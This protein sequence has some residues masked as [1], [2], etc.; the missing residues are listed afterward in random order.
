MVHPARDVELRRLLVLLG[1][2]QIEVHLVALVVVDGPDAEVAVRRAY[3]DQVEILGVDEGLERR[4]IHRRA[5]RVVRVGQPGRYAAAVDDLGGAGAKG[6]RDHRP[7]INVEP[8]AGV[9]RAVLLARV[10]AVANVRRMRVTSV[11]LYPAAADIQVFELGASRAAAYSCARAGLYARAVRVIAAAC[12]HYVAALDRNALGVVGLGDGVVRRVVEQVAARAD[13]RAAE[14]ALGVDPAAG[15]RGVGAVGGHVFLRQEVDHDVVAAAVTL[16]VGG[17][18]A[19]DAGALLAARGRYVGLA[20]EQDV[21]GVATGRVSA[22]HATAYSCATFSALGVHGAVR[23]LD[24]VVDVLL[25]GGGGVHGRTAASADAGRILAARSRDRRAG[26][27]DGVHVGVEDGLRDRGGRAARADAR[28]VHAARCRDV[29]VAADVHRV[30]ALGATAADAR[31]VLACRGRDPGVLDGDSPAP[32]VAATA[33][34]GAAAHHGSVREVGAGAARVALHAGLG[35]RGVDRGVLDRDAADLA[36]HVLQ[37]EVVVGTPAARADAGAAVDALGRHVAVLDG[38]AL[39]AA[40]RAGAD[41]RRSGAAHALGGACVVPGGIDEGVLDGY[42]V[43]VAVVRPKGEEHA[44]AFADGVARALASLDGDVLALAA[45]ACA[46]TCAR[47]VGSLCLNLA[48][49]DCDGGN[50]AAVAPIA[51]RADVGGRAV[52][53]R[54]DVGVLDA[55]GAAVLRAG[56]DACRRA[57]A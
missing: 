57:A 28:A 47:L 35:A 2:G 36:A 42:G 52:A 51:A 39:H 44:H 25:V 16:E 27:A 33:D 41:A 7:G 24:V 56:P 45:L 50:L 12:G 32:G 11:R 10:A 26:D 4:L 8:V 5:C 43:H 20:L 14:S 21:A 29:A 46:D 15:R 40:E 37:A 55:D 1:D 19:A 3:V 22:H 23:D 9:V 17:C 53:P 38:D 30:H 6:V 34:A 48:V 13:A 49:L 31:G 54:L 18:A